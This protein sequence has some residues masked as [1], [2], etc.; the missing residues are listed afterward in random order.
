MCERSMRAEKIIELFD[1]S[2]YNFENSQS[3]L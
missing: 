2:D 1:L 3:Q